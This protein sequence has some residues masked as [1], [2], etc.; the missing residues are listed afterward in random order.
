MKLLKATIAIAPLLIIAVFTIFYLVNFAHLSPLELI[1]AVT[2]YEP[3]S[4]I[5]GMIVIITLFGLKSLSMVFPMVV[6]VAASGIIFDN[7]FIALITNFLGVTLQI[8]IPYAIGRYAERGFVEKLLN[9]HK[10]LRRVEDFKNENELFLCYF[11]RVINILPCDVV[12]MYFGASTPRE[13][14]AT[15]HYTPSRRA[16]TR[17]YYFGSMAGILPGMIVTTIAGAAVT[18]PLSP[19]FIISISVEV[20]FALGSAIYYYFYKRKKKLADVK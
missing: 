16:S 9:K 8:T 5:V 12:S 10:N 14:D 3:P 7:L 20:A 17:N 4:I 2:R 1:E 6:L 18:E 13:H 19:Q 15:N 11:L